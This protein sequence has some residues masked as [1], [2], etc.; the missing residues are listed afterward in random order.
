MEDGRK[1]TTKKQKTMELKL[2]IHKLAVKIHKLAN[3][4]HLWSLLTEPFFF[5]VS[6]EKMS[7]E[8]GL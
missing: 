7:Q 4:K 8:V 3:T 6:Y 1:F 2:M 5:L